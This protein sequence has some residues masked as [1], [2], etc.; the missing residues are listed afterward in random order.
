[1]EEIIRDDSVQKAAADGMWAVV[2]SVVTP[3]FKGKS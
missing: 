2:T 3:S 1:M